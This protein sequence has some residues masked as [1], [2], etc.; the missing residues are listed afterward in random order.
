VP[1]DK[2]EKLMELVAK[3]AEMNGKSPYD[4]TN[5]ISPVTYG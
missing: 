5:G 4:P 1:D 3:I 2:I